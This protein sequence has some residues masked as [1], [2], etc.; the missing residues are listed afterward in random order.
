MAE[1]DNLDSLSNAELRAR[2]L[3]QGLPNI[4]V[5]DS[6]R[7]VL[8]KRLRASLGGNAALPA[9]SPKKSNARRETLQPAAVS[10]SAATTSA[11][12]VDKPDAAPAAS[13][14]RRTIAVNPSDAKEDER[15]RQQQQPVS[16]PQAV[17]EA[18][19][20]AKPVPVKAAP[21]QSR[22]ISNSE[23][24]EQPKE[25]IARKPEP[26]AEEPTVANQRESE[27]PLL[28]N[29][30]IV[31][32]SDDEEDEQLAQAAQDAEDQYS[33]HNRQIGS[34]PKPR[35]KL[36]ATTVNTHDYVAKPLYPSL[37]PKPLEQRRLKLVYE[38][39]PSPIQPRATLGATSTTNSFEYR[40]A[41][42]RYS[43][44]IS[45]PAQSYT[46]AASSTPGHSSSSIRRSPP[47]TY[48]NEFSDD[49]AEEDGQGV[50]FESDFARSLA[51]LR[52]E[53]IGDRGASYRRSV[54]A[55]SITT[56]GRRSLRQEQASSLNALAR[57]WR[58]LDNKYKLKSKLF[59]LIVLLVLFG[60]YRFYY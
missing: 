1:T 38:D 35:S 11:G 51:R 5:T 2:M 3:A 49:A 13:K 46:T 14:A 29:S 48:S 8:V 6:S 33:E 55:S 9:G 59:I 16:K 30:L 25:R 18:V 53:R 15:R 4:P 31:L 40:P 34:N 45:S 17:P 56:G 52:A 36:T 12:Q 43:S 7:K 23:R 37:Q 39:A 21:I 58:T 44:Y 42:G 41:T 20:V 54:P 19:T 10:A 47:R 24:R 26:I 32:E 22:R 57:S 50:K 27:E 28:V 60:V